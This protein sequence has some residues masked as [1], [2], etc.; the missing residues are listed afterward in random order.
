VADI[1][2]TPWYIKASRRGYDTVG[3]LVDYIDEHLT[4]ARATGA[5]KSKSA[6]AQRQDE[7]QVEAA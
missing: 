6:D 7:Q 3:S 5:T 4:A 2:F 1:E